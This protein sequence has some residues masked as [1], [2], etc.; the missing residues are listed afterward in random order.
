MVCK[1][2]KFTFPIQNISI[3]KMIFGM[4]NWIQFDPICDWVCDYEQ[5]TFE[6]ALAQPDLRGIQG[7]SEPQPYNAIR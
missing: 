7:I 5:P 3:M 4:L 6:M 2:G 1:D